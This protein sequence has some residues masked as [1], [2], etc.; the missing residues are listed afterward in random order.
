MNKKIQEKW[1]EGYL[2][3]FDCITYGDGNFVMGNTFSTHDPNN[4]E[5]KRY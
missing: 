5:N 3:G 1:K 4:G 2:P